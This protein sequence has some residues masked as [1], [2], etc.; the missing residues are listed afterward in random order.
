[1]HFKTDLISNVF[2]YVEMTWPHILVIL[3]MHQ[4]RLG[5]GLIRMWTT[6]LFTGLGV[7]IDR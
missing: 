6:V 3:N 4:M 5:L 7:L 1:M 2:D